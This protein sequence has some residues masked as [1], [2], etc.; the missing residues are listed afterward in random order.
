MTTKPLTSSELKTL[1]KKVLNKALSD[2]GT[3][4]FHDKNANEVLDIN[5]L[6]TAIEGMDINE[7]KVALEE[8]ALDTKSCKKC[9]PKLL[10]DIVCGL[11][12]LPDDKW[13]ILMSSPTLA[14]LY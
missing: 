9:L 8:L 10:G 14:A 2:F 6:I 11:D 7:A 5:A 1:I 3:S 4:E 13:E 12:G